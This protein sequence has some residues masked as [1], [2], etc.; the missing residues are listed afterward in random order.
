MDHRSEWTYFVQSVEGGPIKIGYTSQDPETRL[1]NLQ[2][3]SPTVLRIVGLISENRERELHEQF[4]KSRSHGEWFRPTKDLLDFI[5]KNASD[6]LQERL[7]MNAELEFEKNAVSVVQASKRHV[8]KSWFEFVFE[9][10]DNL[11]DN[12]YEVFKEESKNVSCQ[13]DYDCELEDDDEEIYERDYETVF[14]CL[15]DAVLVCE[16][17]GTFIQSIGINTGA[18]FI[19]FVCGPCNSY[20]RFDFLKELA[21]VAYNIDNITGEW[22][23]FAVFWDAGKQIGIDLLRLALEQG[24]N[25]THIFDPALVFQSVI[26][27]VTE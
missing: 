26:G 24:K 14:E 16:Q 9:N 11:F 8:D 17:S 4:E 22:C 19:C 5:A 1:A 21:Q 25:N 12:L 6:T 10:D 15:E 27:E 20:R 23:L 2:T 3:G 7:A 13:D 18:G